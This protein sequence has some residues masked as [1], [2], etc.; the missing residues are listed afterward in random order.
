MSALVAS[1][2]HKVLTPA[3][4]LFGERL[5]IKRYLQPGETGQNRL[6]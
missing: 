4:L 1:R 6:L 5:G 2:H 3:G